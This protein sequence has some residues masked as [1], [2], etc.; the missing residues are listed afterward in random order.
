[1]NLHSIAGPVIAAV[2]PTILVTI[3]TSS[4]FTTN[5]DFSR[6]PN[7]IT[8]T[9]VPAQIQALQYTDLRQIEGMGIVGLRRKLYLY[10]NFQSMVRG[11]QKGG[12]IVT[13]PDGSQWLIAY[14][15]ETYGQGLTGTTGWCSV[16][17]TLQNPTSEQIVNFAVGQ[18][19]TDAGYTFK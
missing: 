11:L 17:C 3:Q 8:L 19:N 14:V 18:S 15:F 10:G 4:G 13:F 5:A 2:N 16:C 12:D 1:M 7:Y 6:T 9:N